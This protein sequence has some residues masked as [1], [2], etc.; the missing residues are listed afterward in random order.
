[1]SDAVLVEADGPVR[2]LTM[3]RPDALNAFDDDLHARISD[4]PPRGQP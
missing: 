2:I 1:M 4:G 3:N